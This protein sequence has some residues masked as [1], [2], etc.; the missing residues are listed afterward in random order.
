MSVLSFCSCICEEFLKKIPWIIFFFG[1]IF[2]PKNPAFL[3]SVLDYFSICMCYPCTRRPNF[4]S[5]ILISFHVGNYRILGYIFFILLPYV[6]VVE[7]VIQL[8]IVIFYETISNYGNLRGCQL[9]DFT[10]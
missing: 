7:H 8:I 3:L 5:I 2:A 9:M 10:R 6:K 4:L 1:I